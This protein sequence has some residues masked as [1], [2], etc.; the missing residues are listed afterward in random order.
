MC[1]FFVVCG[2]GVWGVVVVVCGGGGGCM[3]TEECVW[4][5][6]RSGRKR[7]RMGR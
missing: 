4:E 6:A 2:F 7:R 1:I 5:K 3:D